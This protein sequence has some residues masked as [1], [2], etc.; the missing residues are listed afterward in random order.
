MGGG[1]DVLCTCARI[2]IEWIPRSGIAKLKLSICALTF[3]IFLLCC[4]SKKVMYPHQQ[5]E[6]SFSPMLIAGQAVLQY[7]FSLVDG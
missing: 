1:N 2:S 6:G 5:T 4:P 7:L 3:Y